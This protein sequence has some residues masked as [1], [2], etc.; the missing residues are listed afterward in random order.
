MKKNLTILFLFSF[1]VIYSQLSPEVNKLVNQLSRS[2]KVEYKN[3]DVDG[4]ESSVYKL[5]DSIQKISTNDEIEY[6]VFNGSTVIKSYFSGSFV[7]AK[8]KKLEAL[9]SEFIKK[10]DTIHIKTGCTGFETTLANNLYQEIY[11]LPHAIK[12]RE[13]CKKLLKK[14]AYQDPYLISEL[15][16]LAN[17]YSNW[18]MKDAQEL[19][20]KFDKIAL[21]KSNSNIGVVEYICLINQYNEKKLPHI[22]D[23]YYFKQKYNSKII[24]DYIAFCTQ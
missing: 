8:H 22:K 10:D 18:N 20:L 24:A 15:S 6:L 2:E 21:D 23:F 4:H 16:D 7:R 17:S 14:E 19:I 3:I 9:F 13:E 12:T 5:F 11:N 1:C